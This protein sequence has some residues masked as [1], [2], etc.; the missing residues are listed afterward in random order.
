MKSRKVLII[1]TGFSEF[2]DREISTTVSLG[3]VLTCT[4]LLHLYK[5]DE[6]T[7]V[8]AWAA[9]QLLRDNPHIAELLIFG[10]Q[11]LQKIAVNSYD[12][13]IN[14][15]KDI[16]ICTFLR[17][18]RAQKRYGFYFNEHVHDIAT[19]NRA[20][21]YLLAGQENHKDIDKTFLEI[22]FETVGEKWQGEGYVLTRRKQVPEK[23]DIGFNYAV[24]SKWPTKAWPGDK[25]EQLEKILQDKY[26]IS[27]QQG[28]KNLLK[29]IEW[30]D[31]CRVIVT[32]DS[33]GQAIAA[34]LGKKVIVLYGPTNFRR[35]QGIDNLT[36]IPSDLACPF[37]PCY[38]PICKFDQ[39]CMDHITPE[40][41]ALKCEELLD[42]S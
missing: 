17:Q 35:M 39:F 22:L 30:I 32:A 40:K 38:L 42:R 13:L 7:W 37:M 25:W 5:K 29:Y 41:V 27:W 26:T 31:R 8:T 33:L 1:K 20:T 2:L 15:E 16:G 34:A 23:Y 19:H 18:V 24:G 6:V 10:P 4:A 28:H 9:R 3:D 12:I 36:V 14:L 21:R 11:A